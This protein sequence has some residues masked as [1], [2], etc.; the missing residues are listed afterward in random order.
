MFVVKG[1]VRADWRSKG[2][3]GWIRKVGLDV[4]MRWW[5]VML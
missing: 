3:A 5:C 4:G 2:V 1:V